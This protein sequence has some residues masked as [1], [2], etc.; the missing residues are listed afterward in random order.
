MPLINYPSF[1]SLVSLFVE[2]EIARFVVRLNEMYSSHQH[3][4]K[5]IMMSFVAP[6]ELCFII[7]L[8]GLNSMPLSSIVFLVSSLIWLK[9]PLRAPEFNAGFQSLVLFEL[10][11]VLPEGSTW[12]KWLTGRSTLLKVILWLPFVPWP[13]WGGILCHTFRLPWCST[14]PET[15]NQ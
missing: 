11:V 6:Q 14:A 7:S 13:L 2:L 10:I 3:N 8:L 12:R 9:C 5:R 15:Q 4:A 1:L